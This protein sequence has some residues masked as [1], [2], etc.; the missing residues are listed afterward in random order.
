MTG[1]TAHSV[2]RA[3]AQRDELTKSALVRSRIY[4]ISTMVPESLSK[5]SVKAAKVKANHH[6]E[7]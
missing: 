6:V 2:R 3:N 4:G 7:V 1:E 5:S